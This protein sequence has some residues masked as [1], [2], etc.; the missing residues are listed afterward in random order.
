MCLKHLFTPQLLFIN[1]FSEVHKMKKLSN[2]HT[3]TNNC[4]GRSPA[5]E[6]VKS[7]YDAGFVSLGF[8][9]H[10]TMPGE[11]EWCMTE[12]STK[13]YNEQ[14]EALKKEYEGKME[15]LRGIEWDVECPDL[16]AGEFDYCL[17]SVH[18]LKG[19]KGSFDI[20]HTAQVLQQAVDTL[21]DGNWLK[22]AEYYYGR[23]YDCA[24]KPFVDVLGHIDLIT[25]FNN[26]FVQFNEDD[27]EYQKIALECVDRILEARPDIIFE[28][29]TGAMNRA[30]KK[31]P[32][33]APFI[34]E[35]MCKKG[36]KI[37]ITSDCHSADTLTF[38]FEKAVEACLSAGYKE[39]YIIRKDGFEAIELE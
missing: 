22:M 23:V 19:E 14:L 29:N 1:L 31:R 18:I 3:H 32:Y 38:A 5:H 4:D 27:K 17:G 13:I 34:L 10:A 24:V 2:C 12:E 33:P 6:V 16:K 36:A 25:K 35:H 11:C 37:T 8:S 26:D 39:T 20:D 28:V 7:A 15:I 21:F 9:G 30:G